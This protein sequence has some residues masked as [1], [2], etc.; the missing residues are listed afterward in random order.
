MSVNKAE[1]F[2]VEVYSS[3]GDGFFRNVSAFNR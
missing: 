1:G 3:L 2:N